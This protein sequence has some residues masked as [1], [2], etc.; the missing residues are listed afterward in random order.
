[1][2]I[3]FYHVLS[4]SELLLVVT[5]NVTEQVMRL[6]PCGHLKYSTNV[7]FKVLLWSNWLRTVAVPCIVSFGG[8]K[9]KDNISTLNFYPH[10]FSHK[11]AS[12]SICFCI[13]SA[14][15]KETSSFSYQCSNFFCQPG[16]KIQWKLG[17]KKV[18]C[19]NDF[20]I[21]S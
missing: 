19:C 18:S 16:N 8:F 12:Q 15:Q 6:W 17:K 7:S 10:T 9:L 5:Y 2:L 3:A 1:M 14:C 20:I 13:I 11:E 4:G 21:F